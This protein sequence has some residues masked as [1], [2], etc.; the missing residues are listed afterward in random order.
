MNLKGKV[1]IL[2]GGG[3]GIGRATAIRM[4]NE[5]ARVVI[6]GRTAR[7][8]SAV[9]KRV[10]S[11]GGTALV[12]RLDIADRA[13]L[14]EMVRDVVKRFGKIDVLVNSAGE[15]SLHRGLLDSPSDEIRSIIDSNLV[16]TIYCS[17]E[18][19][20]VMMEQNAGTIIN[21]S[22]LA[23]MRPAL[24]SGMTYCATKA[25]VINFTYFLNKTFRGTNI[26]A[27]VVIPGEVST[28][29][30]AKR[31]IPPTQTERTKMLSAS[32]LAEVITFVAKL[33]PG[34]I[35]E[36]IVIRPAARGSNRIGATRARS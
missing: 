19:A 18:V 34:M 12:W 31:P 26:R 27:S 8:L 35:V 17:Q 24:V 23:G 22:S 36:E 6:V 16:G 32:D 21:I 28:P 2:T 25:A 30:L 33:P 3:S 4:A 15:E 1:C 29:I 5:G 13:A 10:E 20:P 7:K 11:V 9:K 14:Q